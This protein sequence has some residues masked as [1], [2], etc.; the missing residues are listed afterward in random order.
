MSEHCINLKAVKHSLLK[1]QKQFPVINQ[2]LAMQRDPMSDEVVS[3]MLAAYQYVNQILGDDRDIFASKYVGCLLELNHIV[4]CGTDLRVRR[5]NRSHIRRT[6]DR[7]YEQKKSNIGE[8][9][10]WYVAHQNESVWKRASGV[11]IRIL[12][13]PQL[14]IEGNHRTGALIMSYLLV[15]E[16]K[17]PFVLST[18]NAKAYFDPSTLI[19]QTHKTPV[20]QLVKLPRMKKQFAIFLQEEQGLRQ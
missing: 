1:V 20:N 19:K 7:F 10:N 9:I 6:Q 14:F 17:R 8:L 18:A 13:Q 3:N 16:G 5:E 11:Y 12:S 4:L 15:R 2:Q